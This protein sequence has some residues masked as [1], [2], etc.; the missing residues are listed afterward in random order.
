MS[1]AD[2]VISKYQRLEKVNKQWE[3]LWQ[4]CSEWGWPENNNITKITAVGEEKTSR[5]FTDT[6]I[7]SLG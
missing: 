4:E 3:S 5:R 1:T 7:T 2:S 6:V